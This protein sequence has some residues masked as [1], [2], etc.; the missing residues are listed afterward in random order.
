MA[1]LSLA[2][3]LKAWLGCVLSLALGICL[4][5]ISGKTARAVFAQETR[6]EILEGRTAG[7]FP[8]MSGGISFEERKAMEASAT[9]YNLRL[10]FAAKSGAYI[11]DVRLVIQDEKGK[12]IISTVTEGPWFFIDLPPGNYSVKATFEGQ[13]RELKNLRLSKGKSERRY[14]Y[15]EVESGLRPSG[16]PG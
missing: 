8:Y 15:W 2:V 14:F 12:E 5:W 10:G 7:G 16:S 1:K 9:G 13:T 3:R 4:V 11:A 6:G